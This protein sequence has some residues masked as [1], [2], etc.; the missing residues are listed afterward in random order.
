MT[1]EIRMPKASDRRGMYLYAGIGAVAIVAVV[2]ATIDRLI[3]VAPGHD[4]PVTVALRLDAPLAIGP[5]GSAVE[6]VV[7]EAVV[8]VADPAPATLFALWAHPLVTAA[9]VIAGIVIAA[10]FCVR[11]A[12]GL[13]FQRGTA[14]L[15]YAG[16]TVLAAGWL[17]GSL[18]RQM[19]ANGALSA[20][21][22]YGYRGAQFETDWFVIFAMLALVAV[23]VALQVGERLRRD[24]DGL[25]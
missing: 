17:A 6:T 1:E 3:A 19:S 18:L 24:T 2:I 23:A 7:R 21:S 22:D 10:M 16:V 14:L 25:V 20:V 8:T 13:V 15:A 12:R 5:A 4:I 11:V 9:A